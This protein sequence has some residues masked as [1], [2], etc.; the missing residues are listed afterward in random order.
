MPDLFV[1]RSFALAGGPAVGLEIGEPG[2]DADGL[3]R[4]EVAIDWPGE[5]KL[6]LSA[7]GLDRL[8]AL[9][10]AL[11]LARI[12]LEA[13]PEWKRGRLTWKGGFDLGLSPWTIAEPP[14]PWPTAPGTRGN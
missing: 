7:R 12:T 14:P 1:T 6:T 2:R 4:A 10:N 11:A 5:E 9:L 8:D 3:W 13:R